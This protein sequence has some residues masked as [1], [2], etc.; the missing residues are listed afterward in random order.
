M[1]AASYRTPIGPLAVTRVGVGD[2]ITL[3]R[4]RRNHGLP[5]LGNGKFGRAREVPPHHARVSLA[6]AVLTR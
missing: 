2:A 5:V 4:R 1:R 3:D 6:R